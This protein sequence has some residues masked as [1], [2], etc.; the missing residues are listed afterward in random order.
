MRKTT[1]TIPFL[2]LTMLF[3]D[4]S[5]AQGMVTVPDLS[6]IVSEDGWKISN[7]KIELVNDK[8]NN[9]VQF[10]SQPG[11][12]VAWI[13]GFEFHN[14]II[15]ADIRGKDVQGSSFVGI[16][17]RGIDEKTYD[18]VYFRPFNFLSNDP[19][20]K[21]HSVQYISHPEYTWQ[22]LRAEHPEEY[23][24]PVVPAPDPNSFFHVTIVIEKP[25]ISVF[26]NNA[27][28][29][30]LTVSELSERKDGWVGLWVGNY[31]EGSFTNLKIIRKQ[32]EI[33]K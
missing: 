26:V 8:E 31:S 27:K 11:D 23:E 10:N 2:L 14:G 6:K 28:E 21:G 24:N 18:A 1:I 12:G 29:P 25:R 9:V 20:R 4:N 32:T 7:R 22:K 16:A 3:S 17:F 33:K 15:E 30:C 19:L 5:I 13:K